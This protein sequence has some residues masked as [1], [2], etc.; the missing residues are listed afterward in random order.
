M[1]SKETGV[2]IGRF[3]V[4]QLHKGH[5]ELLCY[6]QAKHETVVV[7]LGVTQAAA[8]G[9]DPLPY[10]ARKAAILNVLPSAVVIPLHDHRSD[11]VWSEQVDAA[12]Q[13]FGRCRIYG[14]RDNS[15]KHYSGAHPTETFKGNYEHT[16]GQDLRYTDFPDWDEVSFRSGFVHAHA[17][18]FPISFQ[19]V[20]IAVTTVDAYGQT[21]LAMGK[22]SGE[23]LW[24]FPG[25]FVDPSDDSL[26]AAARRELREEM[27]ISL[28][29]GPVQYIGSARIDDFR[30]RS[31]TDKILTSVFLTRYVFGSMKAS[32]DLAE[33]DWVPIG[34]LISGGLLNPVHAPVLE[35]VKTALNKSMKT[36]K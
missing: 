19:T 28:E 1:M 25:G 5:E 31:S 8:N 29:V 3:Q 11:A 36:S 33:A 7:L 20:D 35:L 15:L 34:H 16:R 10:V 13:P 18:R 9:H 14:G 24:R 4:A 23:S 26:E 30:Y 27:S 32:D 12:L 22:K 21:C 6:V 17:T 2:V